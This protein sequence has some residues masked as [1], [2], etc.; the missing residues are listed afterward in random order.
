[1]YIFFNDGLICRIREYGEETNKKIRIILNECCSKAFDIDWVD[2]LAMD[3][4]ERRLQHLVFEFFF[5]KKT[6]FFVSISYVG[7]PNPAKNQKNGSKYSSPLTS[8]LKNG[9]FGTISGNT[10][11][12]IYIINSHFV[13]NQNTI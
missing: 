4:N 11:S 8:F 12:K 10:V 1:M 7:K 3:K 5:K 13:Y 2:H 6:Q 9:I